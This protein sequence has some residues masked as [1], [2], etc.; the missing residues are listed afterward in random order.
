MLA[1]VAASSSN[2]EMS[3]FISLVQSGTTLEIGIYSHENLAVC[4]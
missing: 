4:G 1:S 2:S 3:F